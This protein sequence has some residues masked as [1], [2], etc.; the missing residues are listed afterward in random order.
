LSLIDC[1]FSLEQI[2]PLCAEI[3]TAIDSGF[4]E[5]LSQELVAWAAMQSLSNGQAERAARF[6]MMISTPD[7]PRRTPRHIWRNLAKAQII[8][9]DFTGG[10]RSVEN[11]LA[12]EDNPVAKT[13][14]LLD[15]ARCHLALKDLTKAQKSIEDGLLLKPQ[16]PLEVEARIVQADIFM[17]LGK[18]EKAKE[19][20]AANALFVEDSRLKPMLLSRMI[21][22]LKA[23]NESEKAEKYQA[24]LNEKF[25]NWKD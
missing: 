18:P 6:F 2:D 23:N 8:I 16:G 24:E 15:Q 5:K 14:A 21:K 10:L 20:L 19:S 1:Y 25:P 9:K 4:S 17:A 13:D 3:D 22:I 12:V 11:V 7:E